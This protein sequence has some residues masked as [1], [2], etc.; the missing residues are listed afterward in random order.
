MKSKTG[1]ITIGITKIDS[2]GKPIFYRFNYY[3]S[4]KF[5]QK[6]LDHHECAHHQTGNLEKTNLLH[7]IKDYMLKED[8][9]DCIAAI[10]MKSDHLNAK[11]FIINTLNEL[12]K[13]MTY[14]GFDEL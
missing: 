8:I 10:R 3:K 5:L 7:N 1:K 11:N 2:L 6:F 14:I 4:S 9:A 12:K 13:A